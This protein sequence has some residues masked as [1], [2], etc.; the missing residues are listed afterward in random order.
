M[1]SRNRAGARFSAFMASLSDSGA[2]ACGDGR[3]LHRIGFELAGRPEPRIRPSAKSWSRQGIPSSSISRRHRPQPSM[4]S[5]PG[6]SWAQP[7][8]ASDMP[9]RR[10]VAGHHQV[11]N[12][13]PVVAPAMA[14][15]EH[16]A[17]TGNGQS[18]WRAASPRCR[19]RA[20]WRWYRGAPPVEPAKNRRLAADHHHACRPRPETRSASIIC[21]QQLAVESVCAFRGS[22]RG[23]DR[24]VLVDDEPCSC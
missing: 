19:W 23:F 21:L 14:R 8:W 15:R 1:A 5:W 11:R 9:K 17:T 12:A 13:A 2:L 22:S 3:Y 4:S 24:A 10:L 7:T 16:H 18:R 6:T 20:R